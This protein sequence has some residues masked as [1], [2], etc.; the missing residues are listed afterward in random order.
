M[1]N[2]KYVEFGLG[3][4]WFVRTETEF[5]DGTE[6]EHWG[7]SHLSEIHGLYLRVWIG[8]RVYIVSSN[9]GF[10][11]MNKNRRAFKL[12]FGIAGI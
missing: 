8:R 9:E 6:T 11:M 10:K 12:L 2:E 3:N 4:R 1:L 5:E 7:F